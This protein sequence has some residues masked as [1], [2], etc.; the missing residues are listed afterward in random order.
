MQKTVNH[1]AVKQGNTQAEPMKFSKRIGSTTFVV[2]V[3]SSRTSRETAQ[4]KIK[5]LI[6]REVRDIA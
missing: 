1:T 3:H 5:R 4:D 6:E 2:S